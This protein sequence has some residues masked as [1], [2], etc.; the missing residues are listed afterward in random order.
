MRSK[1]L[2]IS[3][4]TMLRGVGAT[5]G[6][7]LLDAM[8]VVSAKALTVEAAAPPTRMAFLFFPNGVNQ[9]TWTPEGEGRLLEL[10]SALHPLGAL[11]DEVLVLTNLTNMATDTGDGHYVKD[12][13]FL[14]GTTITRT[15]GAELNANGISVDQL[16]AQRIG[17]LTPLPSLELA[18]EP[19]TTGVDTVVGYTRLYGSHISWSTP[20][21]PVAKEINPRLAF[22]RLFRPGVGRTRDAADDRSVLDLVSAEAKAL[23]SQV[24]GDD[25]H[26]LDEYFDSVR[27]VERRVAFDADHRL[28][29]VRD[30]PAANKDLEALG[31]RI[32]LYHKDPGRLRERSMD[33]T[34]HARLMLDIILLAF[35]TDSTRVASF[36]FGNAVSG[37]DFSFLEGVK[38]SH[39]DIS[40]HEDDKSKLEQ[41][42][43]VTAWHVEQYAYLLER[44]SRVR[45]GEKT[46][47]DNSMVLLGSAL[48]DGNTHNP[49]NLPILLG[50]RAGGTLSPGRH[51]RYGKD[52]PLCNLYV[53]MLHRAGSPVERFADS[54]GPLPG[55]DVPDFKPPGQV[56][57]PQMPRTT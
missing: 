5:L 38:S 33:H 11:K 45:E 47:L 20:T 2:R 46:L 10:S 48:R 19:V 52:T 56:D 4:R 44:M 55:L 18:V 9:G 42:T 7:P 39:H 40:H 49:H 14:T 53:S 36:M 34:E 54:N 15:T 43:K 27:A 12:A 16:A 26:K 6:L 28:A 57:D 25:R 41:Y 22:D 51:I 8:H 3:R 30:D 1:S 29:Q 13:A 31:G 21:T 50:G 37:K 35:Q 32:D 17:N 23:R 24:G